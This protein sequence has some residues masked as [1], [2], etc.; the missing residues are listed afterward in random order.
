MKMLQKLDQYAIEQSSSVEDEQLSMDLGEKSR[1]EATIAHQYQNEASLL[2]ERS[3]EE[4]ALAA[5]DEETS[6]A[7]FD[8]ASEEQAKATEF[9]TKAAEE[10]GLYEAE[11]EEA[12][13]EAAEA[14]MDEAEGDAGGIAT[15]LCNFIPF[16]D[17]VC[18]TLGAASEVS[19]DTILSLQLNFGFSSPSI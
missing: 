18:D 9:A 13:S 11:L 2:E 17:I 14:G 1:S 6:D 12:N 7:L 15:V 5:K 3:E 10:E 16:V 8:K 19:V 4:E